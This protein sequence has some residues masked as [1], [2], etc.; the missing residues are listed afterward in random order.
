MRFTCMFISTKVSRHSSGVHIYQ[1][2]RCDLREGFNGL[3][4]PRLEPIHSNR[5]IPNTLFRHT[6]WSGDGALTRTL[7]SHTQT[8]S[9][10]AHANAMAHAPHGASSQ[11]PAWKHC[12][13]AWPTVKHTHTHT[14]A[15]VLKEV[16]GD[17]A[18]L[19][20]CKRVLVPAVL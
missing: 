6:T 7:M 19:A 20:C 14:P 15:L 2:I 4:T 10:F 16:S 1:L 18:R 11:S 9:V 3:D 13:P 12:S 5:S 17:S 8:N